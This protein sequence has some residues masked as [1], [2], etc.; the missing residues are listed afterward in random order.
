MKRSNTL[1][2]RWFL[3]RGGAIGLV[4]V[5]GCL[6]RISNNATPTDDQLADTN[7][8][9]V[10]IV[11]E[12]LEYPWGITFL[13]NGEALI[14]ERTG[15]L[16]RVDLETGER[17][18]I[19]GSPDVMTEGQGGLLDVTLHPDYPDENWVYMTYSA[20]NDEGESTTHLGRGKFIDRE[21]IEF[22]SIFT[23][24]PFVDSTV[25]FGSR[26]VF[27]PT[28]HLLATVGDRGSKNF[29]AEHVSQDTSNHLGSTLRLTA[30][31]SIP[32]DNPFIDDDE[33]AGA[34]FS[35]GHR[36]VQGMVVHPETG[37]IW[38]SEHGE[39]DGDEINI[40]EAGGNYGWPIA[41]YG[42]TYDT[43]DPIGDSP[44]E[45]DDV[46]DPIHYWECNTGGF[47]PAGMTFTTGETFPEWENNLF[48]GNLADEYLGRFTVNETTL[49]E[50]DPL[51]ADQG[52]RIR[53]VATHPETGYLYVVV[54]AADAPI[55][56]ITPED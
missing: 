10:G 4:G 30:S 1:G 5:A 22:R 24:E 21:S 23:A 17:T 56:R 38:Q 49:D 55:L 54:D 25:H 50:E 27:D 19:S 18:L 47:P 43:D 33:R 8:F 11:A 20:S 2:R 6:D 29:G 12:G 51:L 35:Y 41:H 16:Q 7:T 46:I 45:R 37:E 28:G 9:S 26:I 36:N 40:L 39:Q 32:D 3:R 48:V 42:C 31:G 34:I 15:Q 14:T 53:D 44:A 13:P 52:W